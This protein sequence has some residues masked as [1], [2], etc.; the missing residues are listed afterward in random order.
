M[1]AA[2][3]TPY[4]GQPIALGQLAA[5][6]CRLNLLPIFAVSTAPV[7]HLSPTTSGPLECANLLLK[8]LGDEAVPRQHIQCADFARLIIRR[9]MDYG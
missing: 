4:L 7:P 5:N 8:L 6:R 3:F 2:R 1:P 9:D